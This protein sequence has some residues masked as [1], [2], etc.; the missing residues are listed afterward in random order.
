MCLLKNDCVKIAKT[1]PKTYSNL[2]ILKI[3]VNEFCKNVLRING[4]VLYCEMCE[5]NVV[6]DRKSQVTQ[7]VNTAKHQESIKRKAN[8]SQSQ[9]I[10]TNESFL[11]KRSQFSED[12]CLALLSADIPFHKLKDPVF[13]KFLE[14]YTNHHVPDSYT[15]NSNYLKVCYDRI[16]KKMQNDLNNERI[17]V[18]I[19]ETTNTAGRFIANVVVGA[20]KKET[21]T[22]AYLLEVRQ[23]EKA[24]HSAVSQL[25]TESLKLLWNQELKYENVLLFVTDAA[26]YMIKAA[27]VLKVLFPKMI[28]ITC[29]AHGIHRVAETIRIEFPKVHQL[30]SNVK[31]VFTKSPKRIQAFKELFEG[32]PLPPKPII[33]RWGTWVEAAL[34]YAQYFNEVSNV[35]NLLDKD[36]ASIKIT[37]Q[38]LKEPNLREE[39]IY[40]SAN[41]HHLPAFIKILEASEIQLNTALDAIKTLE[42][43]LQNNAGDAAKRILEKFMHVLEKNPGYKTMCIIGNLL[44]GKEASLEEIEEELSI[45]DVSNFKFAP[46]T[47]CEVERS[48]SRYKSLFRDNRKHFTVEN[49]RMTFITHCNAEILN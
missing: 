20:M 38:L 28:H 33:T 48:F 3:Y 13:K 32:I 11:N 43:N 29:M 21:S 41:F 6:A 25:F 18:S 46:I 19:D 16:L 26:P 8:S 42:V 36:A 2:S 30:I 9:A 24:N 4:N 14:K 35:I 1:M 37:K 17:W 47:S 27:S 7:H 12:L 49:L 15:L 44:K 5:N 22:K 31:K 23:L 10:L 40:I 45:E 34:Y 39:L